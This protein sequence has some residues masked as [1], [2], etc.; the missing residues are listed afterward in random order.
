MQIKRVVGNFVLYKI[1]SKDFCPKV[2]FK[3]VTGLKLKNSH[4]QNIGGNEL[5]I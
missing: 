2:S 4:K 3:E 1:A 5:R